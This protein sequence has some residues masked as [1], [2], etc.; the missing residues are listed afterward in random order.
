MSQYSA[1]KEVLSYCSK[2]KLN[3]AHTIIAMKDI[4]TVGKVICN[5]CKSVHV[6][7]DPSTAK[8]KAATKK[9]GAKRTTK[10]QQMQ[11]LWIEKVENAEVEAKKYSIR[12]KFVIGDVIDHPKFGM[13]LVEA[14]LGDDKI[15]VLFKM[16]EKILIHNK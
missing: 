12:E 14:T 16:E 6:H 11:N 15:E 3:L 13:G 10:A 1:G 4:N 9:T 8:K 2:C 5:T 7:K